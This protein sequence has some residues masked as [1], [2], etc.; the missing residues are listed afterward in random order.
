[1][2]YRIYMDV[3][4]LN[5]PLD[6]LEQARIR[7]EAEAITEIIRNCEVGTWTLVNSDIIEFEIDRHSDT[8]KKELT[9]AILAK[10][11]AYI[12]TSVEIMHRADD[13]MK[14]SFKFHD[15]LHLAFAE[16]GGVDVFLTTDD[17]LLR[18]AQQNLNSIKIKVE[19]PV[20]WLMSTLHNE[21]DTHETNGN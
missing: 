16:A 3:C 12:A 6:D 14:L 21:V 1:M 17:R 10:A 7:L 13:L 20:I 18:K 4:C 5:R 11:K 2:N 8:F 19:N 9:G 15:A